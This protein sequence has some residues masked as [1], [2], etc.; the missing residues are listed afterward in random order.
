LPVS[1]Y[2]SAD[3]AVRSRHRRSAR[4]LV[5]RHAEDPRRDKA[6]EPD[7]VAHPLDRYQS[8]MFSAWSMGASSR[9]V[10]GESAGSGSTRSN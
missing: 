10:T 6:L 5:S 1:S 8:Q 9:C 3:H 7:H 4:C 2:A